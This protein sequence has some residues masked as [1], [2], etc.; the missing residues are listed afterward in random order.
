MNGWGVADT[1][2]S[3]AG[4]ADGDGDDGAVMALRHTGGEWSDG[5]VFPKERERDTAFARI[6]ITEDTE[7]ATV[8]DKLISF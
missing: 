8:F 7:H 4:G 1:P 2:F 5:G 6:L 3:R